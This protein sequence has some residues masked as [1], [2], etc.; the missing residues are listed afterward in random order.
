MP[1]AHAKGDKIV[2]IE[3]DTVGRATH[4]TAVIAVRSTPEH[5]W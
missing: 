1:L 5:V 3:L 2:M 4:E